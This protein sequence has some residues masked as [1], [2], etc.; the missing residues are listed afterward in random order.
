MNIMLYVH[1]LKEIRSFHFNLSFTV[2]KKLVLSIKF[3]VRTAAM[4]G[5]DSHYGISSDGCG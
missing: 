5:F 4:T 3:I 2:E 1:L